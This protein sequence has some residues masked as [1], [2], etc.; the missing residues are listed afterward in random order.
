MK[1]LPSHLR[2]SLQDILDRASPDRPK[3]LVGQIAAATAQTSRRIRIVEE[4]IAG[5]PEMFRGNPF[6]YALGFATDANAERLVIKFGDRGVRVDARFVQWML[7]ANF[8]ETVDDREKSGDLVLYT[9]NGALV[10]AGRFA[11][12]A[13]QSKWALGQ[14]WKHAIEDVPASFGDEAVVYRPRHG[15]TFPELLFR[16]AKEILPAGEAS[17]IDFIAKS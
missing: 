17:M 14:L 6:A 10:H 3:D 1:L 2:S 16:Y 7:R 11:G 13:V 12:G 4:R 9:K 15:H 8:L 5:E